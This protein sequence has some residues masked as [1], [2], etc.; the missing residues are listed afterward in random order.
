[1]QILDSLGFTQENFK[2]GMKTIPRILITHISPRWGRDANKIPPSVKKSIFLRLLASEALIANEE[3]EK[4]RTKLL[5][6]VNKLGQGLVTREESK[7]LRNSA[8]KY[9]LIKSDSDI[10]SLDKVKQLVQRVDIVPPSLIATQ[11]AVESG[12]GTSRFAVEGN[13]L[14]GQW[15]FSNKALKP[16]NQRKHLGNYGLA[17][18]DTPLDSIRSYILNLNTHPAYREF[19][20]RRMLL[21]KTKTP[22]TGMALIDTL[23]SYSERREEYIND[24]ICIIKS[25]NLEWLD[26]TKLSNGKP[27]IIHPE[28]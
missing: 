22:L 6:I 10:L 7:W 8:K 19:R 18:F 26:F 27:V 15:S 2:K 1:M 20:I 14:F 28:E 16:K 24:L 9:K 25:N 4:E 13:A 21:R 17:T 11:G 3:I 23:K 12:W 5:S